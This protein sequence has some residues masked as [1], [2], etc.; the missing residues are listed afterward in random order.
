MGIRE[1]YTVKADHQKQ[2]ATLEAKNE[3]L[4]EQLNVVDVLFHEWAEQ[5]EQRMDLLTS[6]GP[7]HQAQLSL[8][9]EGEPAPA[10]S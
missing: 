5:M 4:D 8:T 7:P 10:G 1:L 9:Q 2:I 6:T 3:H